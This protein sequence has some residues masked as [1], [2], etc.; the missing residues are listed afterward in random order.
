MRRLQF[1][2]EGITVGTTTVNSDRELTVDRAVCL[3]AETGPA[4]G[5]VVTSGGTSN[6]L[7]V[8]AAAPRDA[9]VIDALLPN[10]AVPGR[11]ASFRA[12]GANFNPCRESADP[13]R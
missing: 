5:K 2:G 1:S 3:T 8:N 10:F 9:P 13:R 6:R 11:Q 4:R 7:F 12:F